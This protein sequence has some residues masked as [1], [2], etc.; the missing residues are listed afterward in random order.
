MFCIPPV[1]EVTVAIIILVTEEFWETCLSPSE[2]TEKE[3]AWAAWV[4]TSEN[5]NTTAKIDKEALIET[6]LCMDIVHYVLPAK[7]SCGGRFAG[8]RKK[9]GDYDWLSFCGAKEEI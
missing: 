4:T 3:K 2:E 1:V 8:V 7:W 5:R 9:G 6:F